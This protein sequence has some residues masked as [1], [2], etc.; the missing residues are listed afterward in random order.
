M[1]K[2][3]R[4]YRRSSGNRWSSWCAQGDRLVVLSYRVCRGTGR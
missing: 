4:L 1:P 3:H 2:S